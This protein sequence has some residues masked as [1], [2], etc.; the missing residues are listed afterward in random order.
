MIFVA[1]SD[2]EAENGVVQATARERSVAFRQRLGYR[3][4]VDCTRAGEEFLVEKSWSG[5]AS[6]ARRVNKSW[7]IRILHQR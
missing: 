1:A 7:R 5:R 6:K 4:K 3:N 2:G